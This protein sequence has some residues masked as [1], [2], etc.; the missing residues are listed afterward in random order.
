MKLDGFTPY[1]AED[2][3]KYT[4]RR[5][6]LGLTWGD[7]FDRATDLYPNK[8]GLVGDTARFTYG[9]LRAIVDRLAVTF[10]KLG[11][12]E[13]ERVLVQFPNWHEYV[14]SFFALQKIGAVPV[15]LIPRHSE[16]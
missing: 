10:K 5:W 6:W 15:L 14:L 8:T 9:E 7:V 11:F 13:G 1:A 2:A 4:K 12:A 3:E 16:R